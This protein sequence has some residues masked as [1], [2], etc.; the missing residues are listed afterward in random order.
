MPT[1]NLARNK[2][3]LLRARVHVYQTPNLARNKTVLL[4]A[5]VHDA[6]SSSSLQQNSFVEPPSLNKRKELQGRAAL[7]LNFSVAPP[8]G[9]VLISG[10]HPTNGDIHLRD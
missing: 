10:A 1:P 9:W 7:A 3:V 4:R 6:T 2:T 5:K 8:G